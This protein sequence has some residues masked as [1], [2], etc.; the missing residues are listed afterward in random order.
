MDERVF[1]ILPMGGQ[2]R[3]LGMPFPKPLS[4]IFTDD[5][6][7]PVFEHALET[8]WELTDEAFALVR[9]DTDAQGS[10]GQSLFLT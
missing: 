7:V 3:R 6:I 4:P 5:G 1:G 8:V 9:Q 2:G 10:I